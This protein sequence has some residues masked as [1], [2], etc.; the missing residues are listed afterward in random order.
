V[1]FTFRFNNG[2]NVFRSKAAL[3]PSHANPQYALAVDVA[4]VGA[5]IDGIVESVR[6]LRPRPSKAKR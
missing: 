3:W 5:G 2:H 6:R 1:A 4:G